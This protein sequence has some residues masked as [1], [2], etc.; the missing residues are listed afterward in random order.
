MPFT[1]NLRPAMGA[2]IAIGVAVTPTATLAAGFT[3]E[4]Q[5]H[6]IAVAHALI[7]ASNGTTEQMGTAC[8]GVSIMG[9]GSEIRREASQVPGWALQAHFQTCVAF[10]SVSSRERGKGFMQSTNPC[11][12]IKAAVESLGKAKAGVD[13]DDVVLVAGQLKSTLTSLVGDFKD[14]KAC[15][16]RTVGVFG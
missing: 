11:K 5:Q 1:F 3:P 14:A 10:N 2:V 12:N 15:K 9:G 4:G 7:E 13:A 8:K 6:W 16:F